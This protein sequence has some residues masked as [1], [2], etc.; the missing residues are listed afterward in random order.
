MA[1]KTVDLFMAYT[2]LGAREHREKRTYHRL[3]VGPEEARATEVTLVVT[4]TIE[5]F[6]S[7]EETS[8]SETGYVIKAA[9]LV[10]FIEATG[11][12]LSGDADKQPGRK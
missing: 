3:S 8:R 11:Q 7:G 4:T 1:N 6:P 12:T 2:D 5:E 10:K 9:D